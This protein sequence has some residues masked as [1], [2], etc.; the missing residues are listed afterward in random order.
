MD[1]ILP[2][3]KQHNLK[4]LEDTAQSVGAYYH[5][6]RAGTPRL[7]VDRIAILEAPHVELTRGGALHWTVGDAIDHEAAHAADAFAAVVIERDR[8]FSTLGEPLVHD[9]EH[10]EK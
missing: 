6:K 5:G 2:I 3:T 10:L 1:R 7:D 8:D 4:I 9:V